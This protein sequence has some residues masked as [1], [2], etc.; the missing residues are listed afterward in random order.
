MAELV[1]TLSNVSLTSSW[2]VYRDLSS[3]G[4]VESET[5]K[6]ITSGSA[7]RSVAISGI[8]SG[9]HV[10]KAVLTATITT[11]GTSTDGRI[12]VNDLVF[13]GTRKIDAT[14]FSNGTTWTANF[15]YRASGSTPWANDEFSTYSS[16]KSLTNIVLTLTTGTGSVFDG[17][18]SSLNEGDKIIITEGSS[19]ASYTLVH[20]SY[21]SGKALIFRD[22]SIGTCKWRYS[23]PSS[24]SANSYID[25]TLDQYFINT[26][27]P[28]LPAET[29]QFLQTITYPVRS[30]ASSGSSATTIDRKACTLSAAES[31]LGG[32]SA[33]GTP[34]NY[35]NTLVYSGSSNY[36]TR[37]PTGGMAEYAQSISNSGGLYNS[38]VTY[39]LA[40]RPTL[41]VLEEQLV[42]YSDSDGG[43][44]FCTKCTAPSTLYI[45]GS[46][47]NVTKLNKEASLTL[48]WSAGT[49]GY[50]API[51]G[52]AVWYSTS[53]NG[54]YELYGTTTGTSMTVVAPDKMRQVYYFKVQTLAPADAD[55]CNSELSSTYRSAATKEGN[56][57]YYDGTKWILA[58]VKYYNGS[59]WVDVND[60]QY[61]NGSKWV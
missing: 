14:E 47:T 35:T 12:T 48:S 44:I 33:Y 36:W 43:Y 39:N 49:A 10:M 59:K 2:T 25:S 19:N 54:T 60:V 29:T 5:I 1:F 37:E 50:N 21:N 41:G 34:W 40:M 42:R 8:P 13:S 57:S 6:N 24:S 51:S 38:S 18:V 56:V 61:Y 9:E 22:D 32:N 11:S 31:G 26:W 16:Q 45:N 4:A 53:A 28:T 46:A 20:H 55:Y 15:I 30:S 7:S 52:Y 27:Y 58:A 3:T 17:E 23:K